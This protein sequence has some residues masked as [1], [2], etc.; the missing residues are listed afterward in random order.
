MSEKFSPA[1][2]IPAKKQSIPEI[3]KR[4]K[5]SFSVLGFLEFLKILS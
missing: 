4:I 1:E 5:E 3:N 2:I